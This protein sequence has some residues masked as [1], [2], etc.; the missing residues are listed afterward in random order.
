VHLALVVAPV[1]A[2]LL[3][4]L[5]A[6][7][8]HQALLVGWWPWQVFA[9]AAVAAT[10]TFLRQHRAPAADPLRPHHALF[11]LVPLLV[12]LNGLTPYLEL[13][14]GYGWN[15]YAN[16]RTVDGDSNHLIVRR[17]LPLTDEQADPVEILSS[18]DPELQRSTDGFALP[19]RQLRT[20]LARHP[21]VAITYRRAGATVSL[22]RADERPELVE[23]QPAWREKVQLFRAI[24]LR[25]PTRCVPTFGPAR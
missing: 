21:D 6:L 5:D 12:V 20:Y 22:R 18:S 10:V 15:M 8:A 11:A 25:E 14:T 23:A 3:V 2:A 16:L 1:A 17:T 13:K 4:A 9:V 7:D 24:D 19:W